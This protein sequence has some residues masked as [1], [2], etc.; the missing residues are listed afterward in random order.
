MVV[1]TEKII[2]KILTKNECIKDHKKFIKKLVKNVRSLKLQVR[3]LKKYG[4]SL[5]EIHKKLVRS[6]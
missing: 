3:N 2:R 6:S 1:S 5:Y 4:G